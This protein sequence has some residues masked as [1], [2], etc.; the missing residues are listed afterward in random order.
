MAPRKRRKTPHLVEVLVSKTHYVALST[1]TGDKSVG[2]WAIGQSGGK[3]R[4]VAKEV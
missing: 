4:S 2:N 3:P 1:K